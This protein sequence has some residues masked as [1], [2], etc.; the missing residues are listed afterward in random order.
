MHQ[1]LWIIIPLNLKIQRTARRTR[2]LVQEQQAPQIEESV[3]EIAIELSP[4][5]TM[6]E[7]QVD[8]DQKSLRDFA[9]PNA[10]G[11][12]ISIVRPIVNANNFEIKPALIQ[13]IQ[14]DQFGCNSTEDPNAYSANFPKICNTMKFN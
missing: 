3:G 4:L 8:C 10:T 5:E 6:V 2:C 1:T 13:M 14:Q 9:L 11:S 12:Q 7:E